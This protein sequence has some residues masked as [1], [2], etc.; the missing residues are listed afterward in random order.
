[1]YF[2]V[3]ERLSGVSVRLRA[4]MTRERGDQEGGLDACRMV[5]VH[6]HICLRPAARDREG[7]GGVDFVRSEIIYTRTRARTKTANAK[8]QSQGKADRDTIHYDYP[9]SDWK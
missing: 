9:R 2:V 1:M 7:G 5:D 4:G 3:P 6:R 8:R